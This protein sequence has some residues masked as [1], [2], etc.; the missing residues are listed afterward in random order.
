MQL[1]GG[2]AHQELF[3]IAEQVNC[4]GTELKTFIQG[5]WVTKMYVFELGACNRSLQ[6]LIN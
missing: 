6:G 3:R 5:I 1:L 4:Y 2:K